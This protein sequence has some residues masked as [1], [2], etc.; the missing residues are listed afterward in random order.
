MPGITR[1]LELRIAGEA[2]TL[3]APLNLYRGDRGIDIFFR[4]MDFSYD[5]TGTN[6]LRNI[7]SA[8]YNAIVVKPDGSNYVTPTQPIVDNEVK[9]T[10]TKDLTDE[11]T[12][13]GTYTL[14][15]LLH[16]AGDSR[17]AIPPIT[18]EV[19]EL[20][21]D[22]ADG[23]DGQANYSTTNKTTIKAGEAT[24]EARWEIG[25]LITADKLNWTRDK[26]IQGAETSQAN[27]NKISV[28]EPKVAT[29]E[30]KV[31]PLQAD[32]NTLKEKVDDFQNINVMN[33]EAT[34]V[35]DI[36]LS[37]TY[38]GVTK[39]LV[40]KGKTLQNLVKEGQKFNVKMTNSYYR[41]WADNSSLLK[42][43]GTYT[44]FY[45]H[46]II[47]TDYVGE[48]KPR[49]SIVV[50]YVD[51]TVTEKSNLYSGGKIA[52]ELEN[53]EIQKVEWRVC[54]LGVT[55]TTTLDYELICLEGDHTAIDSN[56]FT[57]YF[58]SITSVG[59]QED[60][61]I[62]V[63]TVGKNLCNKNDF[64]KQLYEADISSNKHAIT[65]VVEDG[66][67]CFKIMQNGSIKQAY[68]NRFKPNTAY[69]ISF[70]CKQKSTNNST[71]VIKYTDGSQI[72][73]YAEPSMGVF[74]KFS[75][76][77]SPSKQIDYISAFWSDG[78][79]LFIDEDTIQIE[80][81]TKAT[82]Y[83]PYVADLK[84]I[85]LPFD[86]GLK[87]LPNGVC[88]EI[89]NKQIT[90]RVGRIVLNG[91]E[92]WT[93]PNKTSATS[94]L[95]FQFKLDNVL[96]STGR[97]S[98]CDK[99]LYI[100]GLWR[101]EP[102]FDKRGYDIANNG[103]LIV[104]ELKSKLSTQDVEGWKKYLQTNPVTV[105]Y[106]LAQPIIHPLYED[107]SLRTY[108]GVTHLY[109]EN[110]ICGEMNVSVPSNRDG[111]IH[112]N[113]M[114]IVELN[115][116]LEQTFD[117]LGGKIPV[118]VPESFEGYTTIKD[119][120]IGETQQL[121]VK[122]KTLQNV[123]RLTD[124]FASNATLSNEGDVYRAT[125][126]T[127]T[128]SGYLGFL[129]DA[130]LL[131]PNTTYTMF[132]SQYLQNGANNSK[133]SIHTSNTNVQDFFTRVR[134]NVYKVTTTV[135][136]V[137]NPMRVLFY[138]GTSG[139]V[140]V[141]KKMVILEGDWT[142][143]NIPYFEGVTSTGEQEDNKILIKS[144]GKNLIDYQKAVI[145]PWNSNTSNKNEIIPNGVRIYRHTAGY[146]PML[147]K[148]W[149]EKGNYKVSGDVEYSHDGI[150]LN[151]MIYNLYG[152]V[153]N[154]SVFSSKIT[155]HES[156]W[157]YIGFEMNG[158]PPEGAYCDFINIQLEYGEIATNYEQYIGGYK[159]ITLP[160]EGGLKSLPNGE[161]DTYKNGVII[162]RLH[163]MLIPHTYDFIPYA[164]APN[165]TKTIVF[166]SNT[167]VLSHAWGGNWNNML[168]NRF[169]NKN[170]YTIDEEGVAI[171]S[172]HKLIFRISRDKL[173]TQ[174]VT[175]FKKWLQANE[176]YVIGQLQIP[177]TYILEG[178]RSV[179]SHEG[180][181]HFFQENNIT[182]N[183]AML[184]PISLNK[185]IG[186]VQDENASLTKE[187]R[188]L[189]ED[190]KIVA[191]ALLNIMQPI[192][193]LDEKGEEYKPH[194][195]EEI[196]NRL[197][198]ILSR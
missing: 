166:Y 62:I 189:K 90:Q 15:F 188:I 112:S 114:E 184:T 192:N 55:H 25:E 47:S 38:D 17:V 64:Y 34:G 73:L 11:M 86:N 106:E 61:K 31:A 83:E 19:K 155:L 32:V 108:Q 146:I 40:V 79:E 144:V 121:S 172:N 110:N 176:T 27:S 80:E 113:T 109:Q 18:I 16:G 118:Y 75:V 81:D 185:S 42:P 156:G 147:C 99:L 134:D 23:A 120:M 126:N 104:R 12:E 3:S 135:I 145:P 87:S 46:K 161:C 52:F 150:Q 76:T 162:Q 116:K 43:N 74:K 133:V 151:K 44:L 50:T 4:I 9:F 77:T 171:A 91:S 128:A 137:N 100:D 177:K 142:N 39:D 41:A 178:E 33:Q 1:K 170:V 122:G 198:E 130:T 167:S 190:N 13:I 149:L 66:R 5:F 168:S 103:D 125:S 158:R 174:D 58:D 69:T 30:K 132:T 193:T 180:V 93:A 195:Q 117:Y 140:E 59:E 186:R 169:N 157:Y 136:D 115:D 138:C 187:N 175:G 85:K 71:L 94:T 139:Y 119:S 29:L 26:A 163:K 78:K 124:A 123:K 92:N 191:E 141:N 10:I 67:N 148:V 72:V 143:Y 101:D 28:L 37:D 20:I 14:Q 182:T 88:D 164:S 22:V 102:Q 56:P 70:F 97:E 68:R 45:N 127:S 48:L 35:G 98:V 89:Q 82:N 21:A 194:T 197:I 152:K 84:T 159:E 154:N 131:K 107:Y 54:R 57:S 111:I 160:F 53:K 105:Y 196:I 96:P 95:C 2:S 24:I 179:S 173:E 60:N 165:Q 36:S 153:L 129:V 183:I 8:R 6:L 7:G 49:A 63:K 181:T 51:N 65:R